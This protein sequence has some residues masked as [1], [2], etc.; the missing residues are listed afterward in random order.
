[1]KIIT[2]DSEHTE[3]LKMVTTLW[4]APEG[5]DDHQRFDEL[6]SMIDAYETERWPIEPSPTQ[7]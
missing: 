7:H 4:N 3:A 5:T 2:N 1:M 6:V